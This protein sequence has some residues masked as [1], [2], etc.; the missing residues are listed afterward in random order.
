MAA[1]QAARE[2]AVGGHAD[3]EL[4]RDGQDPGLDGAGDERVLDLEVADRVDGGGAA[5]GVGADLGEADVA[6]VAG[7]DQ[8]GDRAD[9]LLDRHGGVQPGGAVDVDV[10][11]AQ[12]AQGVGEGGLD[13]R[14]A[15]VV[16]E[17]LA[18]RAALGAELHADPDV[19]AVAAAQRLVDQQLVVAHAV[20]VAGVEQGDAGVE[21]RV[22]GRDALGLVGGA[23]EVRH[24]HAAEAEGGDRRAGGAELARGEVAGVLG[25]GHGSTMTQRLTDFKICHLKS[26]SCHS[27]IIGARVLGARAADGG[28]SRSP[29]CGSRTP[30]RGTRDAGASTP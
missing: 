5:Q 16:A 12:A 2:H 22:D 13:R 1:E 30:G 21:G 3:A 15:G 8:L 19:L 11:G 20:E 23:V 10:V 4:A 24:A 6:D 27:S 28:V 26:V 25:G 9:G 7:L 18:V 17:P 29:G 14:R